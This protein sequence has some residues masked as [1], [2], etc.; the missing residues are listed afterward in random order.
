MS[1]KR[2]RTAE[3]IARTRIELE[4][5]KREHDGSLK[6][7]VA[8]SALRISDPMDY[9][10]EMHDAHNIQSNIEAVERLGIDEFDRL[11]REEALTIKNQVLSSP[12]GPVPYPDE[13][14]RTFAMENTAFHLR[15]LLSE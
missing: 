4:L 1:Y 2:A 5:I 6:A 12:L 15:P 8:E 13:F 14:V 3:Q 11:Y 10:G 7:F 9:W